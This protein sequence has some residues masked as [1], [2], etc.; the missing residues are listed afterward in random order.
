M[1]CS[2]WLLAIL[3]HGFWHILWC[4]CLSTKPD[5]GCLTS[6]S[7]SDRWFTEKKVPCN[8]CY[9]VIHPSIFCSRVTT[10]P[11]IFYSS[12]TTFIMW[13]YFEARY[14]SILQKAHLFWACKLCITLLNTTVLPAR[15]MASLWGWMGRVGMHTPVLAQ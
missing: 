2:I 8:R 7:T 9:N 15:V 4:D 1:D 10:S 6:R 5:G 12:I 3:I 14:K 11:T 13:Q